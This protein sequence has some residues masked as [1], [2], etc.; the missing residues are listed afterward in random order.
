MRQTSFDRYGGFAAVR[1]VVLGFYD[2]V[3]E[4]PVT[5]PFSARG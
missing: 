2:K 3:L 5:S 4:S 1:R